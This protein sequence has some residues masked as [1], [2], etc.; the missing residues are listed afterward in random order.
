MDKLETKLLEIEAL[1]KANV[2]LGLPSPN[3]PQMPKAPTIAPIN[4]KN[5]V[6]VAQQ[7]ADP[8]TKKIAVKQAK[9]ILKTDKNGQWKLDE[10]K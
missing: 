6:K 4:K 3:T 10:A 9:Q 8:A 1:L 2:P 7:I 5:P